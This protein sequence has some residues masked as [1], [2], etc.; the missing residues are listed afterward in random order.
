LTN[1]GLGT[2]AVRD[3]AEAHTDN[4]EQRMAK[5]AAVFR[6]LVW[7]TGGLGAILTIILAPLLSTLTFGNSDY[8]WTF[9]LLSVTLLLGQF[10]AAQNVLLQGTRKLKYLA[11][12]NMLGSISS[13]F[14]A[15]PL[16]FIYGE[17][18]IVPA[19]IMMG[20]GAYLIAINFSRKVKIK[21]VS[22][23]LQE[24]LTK[25][26]GML[27]LG[28]M[29]SLSG[30]IS[31]IASYLINIYIRNYGNIEDVGLYNAG[32]Q[33]INTYVGLVF[34]A[35]ATDYY[36]RLSGVASDTK[37]R[38]SL[39]NQQGEIAILILF[40]IILIF[41]VF[42]PYIVQFLYSPKFS[43]INQMIIWAA[44]AMLF[45]A[46]SWTIAMQ[47][48]AKGSSKLFLINEFIA[49]CYLVTFNFFGYKYFGLTGLG[50]SFLLT[51]LVYS[52]QVYFV[53]KF[54][55]K[56]VLDFNLSKIFG[57]SVLTS[58]L[59]LTIVLN[60]KMLMAH[61]LCIFLIIA[62]SIYSFYHLNNK[63]NLLAIIKSRK[64]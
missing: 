20:F 10:T 27:K 36:P 13:L 24:S 57:I 50:Y 25:G 63:T 19:I 48:L 52:V 35:M 16:Y 58:L 34:T 15:L 2:S 14:I 51:Y 22:V 3:I 31:I 8:T 55:Y 5:T 61:L 42:V 64:K 28:F 17:D 26:K 62:S 9:V 7:I 18:G 53:T 4:D 40:P 1:F 38:N 46:L 32:F 59:I 11:Y 33:I 44:F 12:A 45:K 6:K 43:P 60:S 29:L 23:N 41:I 39:V 21:K 54:Y 37:K 30:L 47:F 49:H 56:F